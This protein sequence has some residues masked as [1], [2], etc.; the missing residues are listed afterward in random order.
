MHVLS[1][2]I[3]GLTRSEALG[4]LEQSMA[5]PGEVKIYVQNQMEFNIPLSSIE[6]KIDFQNTV[7]AA[8]DVGRTG[9][10][11][12]DFAK[13][14][15]VFFKPSQIELVV[16][17]NKDK[18]DE[19]IE[20]ISS[21]SPSPHEN[22][23]LT[24]LGKE[25]QFTQGVPGV[26]LAKQNL[27]TA[28]ED[29]LRNANPR[30]VLKPVSVDPTL[31]PKEQSIYI[32][33]G[34][35]LKDKTLLLTSENYS[36]NYSGQEILNLINPKGGY[37]F[38]TISPSLNQVADAVKT[39]PQN[40]VFVFKEGRVEE[41]SP[42][43]D[44]LE[45]DLL[46]LQQEIRR[47][48]AELET[49]G[50]DSATSQIPVKRTPPE[51]ATEDI[52]DLGISEL[53]GVGTSSFKGSIPSRVYNVSLAASRLNGVLIEPGEVFSFVNTL[54]DISAL[55]GYK[56]AYVIQGNQTILGDGGGVC[57]VSTTFFRAAL[58]TGLPI[59]ERHPHSYRVGY[60]EQDSPPGI[61]A[62]IYHPTVDIKIKNDTPGHI[63]IQTFTDTKNMTLRFEFYGTS[64]GRVSTISKPVIGSITPPPEDLYIDAPT[65]PAG[66]I[67]QVDYKAWGAKV[68]FSY[69][70]E[71]AGEVIFESTYYSN[72]R[73]WQAKFLRGTGPVQ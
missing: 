72:Y 45:V 8:Y 30:V 23:K 47:A 14:L 48:L 71:R 43:K 73:P 40:P 60:Y 15:N 39:P 12:E 59:V 35:L 5:L 64:D 38:E 21:Q 32:S 13:V 67:K 61:D 20:L 10:Q 18:L 68:N 26:Y 2:H 56:Q 6:A 11:S 44:G 49:T 41:F 4:K 58:N 22:P 28:L 19:Q 34:A 29:A 16:I 55:T 25:I 9:K 24:L 53:V 46:A 7:S 52:N 1:V 69:K 50:V 70:V 62:T 31:T 3:G 27:E 51:F 66:E 17:Y 36:T 42:A 54:G 33:R 65:L 57:Q 37:A 63:L